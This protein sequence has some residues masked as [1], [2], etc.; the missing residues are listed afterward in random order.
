M[1]EEILRRDRLEGCH[2][3]S[4]ALMHLILAGMK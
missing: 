2:E 3:M 4:A 1:V